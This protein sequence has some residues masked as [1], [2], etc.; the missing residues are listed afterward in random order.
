MVR[1]GRARALHLGDPL[2]REGD[3]GGDPRVGTRV[4]DASR[5]EHRR[6]E[7]QA[8]HHLHS[9]NPYDGW[10]IPPYEFEGG[11]APKL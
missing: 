2:R 10:E 6:Q 7:Q 4:E 8:L 11:P 9:T 1:V 5:E 3:A